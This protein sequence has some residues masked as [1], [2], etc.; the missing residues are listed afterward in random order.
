MQRSVIRVA[1]ILGAGL[2]LGPSAF[3][4][5]WNNSG[6]SWNNTA[7]WTP[8]TV[9]NSATA[10]ATFGATVGPLNQPVVDGQFLLQRLVLTNTND[11]WNVVGSSGNFLTFQ[12]SNTAET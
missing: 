7:S 10:T 11:D 12:N 4:Q 1:L 6:T 9:P 8:N 2:I 3:G 5:T